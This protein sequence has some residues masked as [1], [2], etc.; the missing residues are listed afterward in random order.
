MSN[1]CLL[2]LEILSLTQSLTYRYPDLALDRALYENV[3]P[4]VSLIRIPATTAKN[5]QSWGH[6]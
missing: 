3:S 5:F 6:T 2:P 4:K 1:K